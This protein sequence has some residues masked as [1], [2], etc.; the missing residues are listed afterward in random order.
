M[1]TEC[2]FCHI[3]HAT[4]NSP[5]LMGTNNWNIYQ[6]FYSWDVDTVYRNQEQSH[7]YVTSSNQLLMSVGAWYVS[8]QPQR[9]TFCSDM[10]VHSTEWRVFAYTQKANL[11]MVRWTINLYT[12]SEIGEFA[13]INTR[14][15]CLLNNTCY[16]F[17][18]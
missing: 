3:I 10:F 8:M 17:T 13:D 15:S 4:F 9:I 14:I 18:L 2:L 11:H 16:A 5:L 12:S 6:M 7:M 1:I